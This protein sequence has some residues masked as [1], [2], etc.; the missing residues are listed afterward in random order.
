MTENVS[1]RPTEKK[2]IVVGP[3]LLFLNID[4]LIANIVDTW[5]VFFLF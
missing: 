1:L 2:I 5:I 3:C 4:K